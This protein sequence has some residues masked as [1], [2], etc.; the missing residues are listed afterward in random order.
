[1]VTGFQYS[2]NSG[3]VLQWWTGDY[4]IILWTLHVSG[5]TVKHREAFEYLHLNHWEWI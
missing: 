5:V 1:M 3:E 4:S 2:H